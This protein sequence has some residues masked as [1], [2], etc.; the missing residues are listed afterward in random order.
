LA[1]CVA[2]EDGPGAGT[3]RAVRPRY[4]AQPVEQALRVP[5]HLQKRRQKLDDHLEV[6]PGTHRWP[7]EPVQL[8]HHAHSEAPARV[9]GRALSAAAGLVPTS[10]PAALLVH[11]AQALGLEHQPCQLSVLFSLGGIL[12]HHSQVAELDLRCVR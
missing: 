11:S 3:M 7:N 12:D 5:Q 6:D 8:V 1:Q 4:P 9:T 10:G 2:W